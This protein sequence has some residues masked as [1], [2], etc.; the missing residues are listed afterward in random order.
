MKSN[1]KSQASNK[2]VYTPSKN[3]SNE[4]IASS[5]K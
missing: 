5:I 1:E 4:L 2:K 3:N